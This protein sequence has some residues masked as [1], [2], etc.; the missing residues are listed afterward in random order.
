MSELFQNTA[1]NISCVSDSYSLSV[2]IN[3]NGNMETLRIF[4][5][6]LAKEIVVLSE[7]RNINLLKPLLGKF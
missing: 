6:V 7:R 4:F 3:S 2:Q 1:W 5:I